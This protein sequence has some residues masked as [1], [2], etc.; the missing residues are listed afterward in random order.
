[1]LKY[2]LKKWDANKGILEERLKN[3]KTLNDCDY[4]YLVELVVECI[5][6]PGSDGFERWDAKKITV[7][8]D[9]DYQ[10]TLLFLIPCVTYQPSEDE[11]LMTYA[12]YGSCPGCDTLQE[13]QVYGDDKCPT[14]SQLKDYMT[15]C[16]DLVTNMIKPY[17]GGW[18]FEEDFETVEF[19]KD[20]FK[21]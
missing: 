15:L 6:N 8:D 1:M 19:E 14:E 12:G 16:K 10:G 9:G 13:I 17:N 18:R 7:V 3:D 21:E 5:I 20:G 2:C 4:K 11:Y